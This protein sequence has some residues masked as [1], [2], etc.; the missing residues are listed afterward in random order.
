VNA[1][2]PSTVT[3]GAPDGTAA[4]TL[5]G[6]S[7]NL[8]KFRITRSGGGTAADLVVYYTVG[9]TATNGT[10]YAALSGTATILAGKTTVDILVTPVN[11]A[12]VEG[13]ETVVLT[14][15]AKPAYKLGTAVSATVSLNDND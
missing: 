1:V 7:V 2:N 8:G 6:A 3:V 4:E 14:L 5:S 10:D 11:D 9:G 13:K 12:V 15:T